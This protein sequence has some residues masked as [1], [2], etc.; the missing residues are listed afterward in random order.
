MGLSDSGEMLFVFPTALRDSWAPMKRL[1]DN[2]SNA[3]V[4]YYVGARV[5]FSND[6]SFVNLRYSSR[7]LEA[8]SFMLY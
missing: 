7:F 1:G 5:A 4:Y 2:R 3:A 8:I 6:I